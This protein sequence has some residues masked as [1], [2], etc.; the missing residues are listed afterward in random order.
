[1]SS[2]APE[3]PDER[4][5]QDPGTP[6]FETPADTSDRPTPDAK[7]AAAERRERLDDEDREGH[8]TAP[9]G[10]GAG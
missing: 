4:I 10:G 5:D 7:D 9:E 3:T 6:G 2:D 1:M 8:Q